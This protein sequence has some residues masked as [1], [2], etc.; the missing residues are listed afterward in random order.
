MADRAQ[1][2]SPLALRGNR[3]ALL[4]QLARDLAQQ[5]ADNKYT[6]T[7]AVSK[8][9]LPIE[10]FDR[11]RVSELVKTVTVLHEMTTGTQPKQDTTTVGVQVVMTVDQAVTKVQAL[12]SR[13]HGEGVAPPMPGVPGGISAADA[14]L[15]DTD[16]SRQGPP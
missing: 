7:I 9:G 1:D 8:A 15:L 10:G 12:L 14:V 2:D 13:T 5:L 11:G 6:T 3:I 4:D 16:G